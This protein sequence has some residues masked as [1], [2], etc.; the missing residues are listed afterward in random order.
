VMAAVTGYASFAVLLLALTV[1]GFD[2]LRL[3]IPMLFC[4]F[5]FLGLVIPSTMVLSLEHHGR[6][7]G[8]AAALAGTLQMVSGGVLIAIAGLFFDGSSLPMV[9]TIALTAVGAL[10]IATAT[11]RGRALE[12]SPAE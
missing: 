12:T 10:S 9:A 4:S 8:L 7:A 11:L 2:S 1:A 6:I 5:A 3:L